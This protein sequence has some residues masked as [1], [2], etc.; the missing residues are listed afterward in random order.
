AP[1]VPGG[2]VVRQRQLTF[3]MGM[4]GMGSGA[5]MSFTIDGRTFDPTRDDQTIRV[6]TTEE[7]TVV[8]TSPMVH[9]FHLHVWPAQVVA[10]STGTPPIGIPQDTVLIPAHGWVRLRIPFLDHP[11]RS[12][13]HCHTL[14]HEDAGMMATAHVQR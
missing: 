9:P 13:Y 11:G 1:F 14:D 3:A 4:G 8:N 7:W 12:V 2:P 6:G 10:D 5:M